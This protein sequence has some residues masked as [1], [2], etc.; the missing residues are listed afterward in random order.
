MHTSRTHWR[1]WHCEGNL[2]RPLDTHSLRLCR[3]EELKD[4]L[5]LYK[6]QAS[7]LVYA[8]DAVQGV[9]DKE[10]LLFPGAPKPEG[11]QSLFVH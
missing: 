7:T 10:G 8:P 11:L 5:D 1:I 4:R 6:A 2:Y 9:L 3:P